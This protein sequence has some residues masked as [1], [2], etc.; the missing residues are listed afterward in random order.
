MWDLFKAEW[1][2]FRA[3]AL[4]FAA[5]QLVALGFM[6]RV[7]DLAQQ[8]RLVYQVI[9]GVYMATGLLLGLYQM[10]GY[11]RANTWLNLLHRP[12]PQA[13][14]AAALFGGGFVALAIAVL[15][16]LLLLLAWQR[17]LTA[18]VVDVRHLLLSLSG[19]LIA[20]CGYLAGGYAMLANRRYSFCALVPL[21]WIGFAEAVGLGAIAVQLAALTLL[22]AMVL[23]AF[24]PDLG[25]PPRGALGVALTAVPLQMAMW[26]A[27]VLAGFG[28]EL[29]WI[30]Q[31]SHPNN[32][33]IP[34]PGGEKESENAEAKEL[35]A[36]GLRDVHSADAA[37]WREQAAISDIQGIDAYLGALPVRGQLTNP[38]PLEFDDPDRRVRWV[39]SHDRMRF[40]GYSLVD[41][42]AAGTLGVDG[43][44]PF[45]T[46]PLPG[47]DGLLFGKRSIYQYVGDDA[48]PR[49]LP[50]IDV[51]ATETLVGYGQVGD[52]MSVLSDRA[53]YFY[54]LRE[55]RDGDAR[56]T[57]RQRMP[58][59][60]RIGDLVRIDAMALLD[61]TLVSFLFTRRSYN[62]EGAA[63]F[64]AVLRVDDAGRVATVA[65][66]ALGYDYPVAWR[67]QN[68]YPSPA[69]YALRN[70]AVGAFA[71]AVPANDCD[72][73]P[74]PRGAWTIAAVL[75]ALSLLGALWRTRRIGL[76]RPARLLWCAVCAL[77]GVP[78]LLALWLLYPL[79]DTLDAGAEATA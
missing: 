15:L 27:L 1:S 30:A 52:A 33:A 17:G 76:P 13:R 78:A 29:L 53:L 22:A 63:P 50:R 49:V 11:R 9:G 45:A 23:I 72:T 28:V 41:K 57:P 21:L 71:G 10:G 47:A 46:P 35:I 61:G 74:P 16:P 20:C 65:H 3:W 77:V 48:A 43:D 56:L 38:A 4:A 7:V 31:G 54:D 69:L 34:R 73:P 26:V 70:A 25:A 19:L 36:F 18:R 64:Q 12:L 2:R 59:P 24:K 44:A 75:A 67:Y 32:Q 55:F 58:L 5:V 60:G 68:W 40:E 8:P 51:P 6:S 42:R 66:R 14:I 39:F 62:A 37:L 79:P